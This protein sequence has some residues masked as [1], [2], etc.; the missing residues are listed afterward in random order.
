MGWEVGG[1][2]WEGVRGDGEVSGMTGERRTNSSF[3]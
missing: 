2:K 3:L 1:G